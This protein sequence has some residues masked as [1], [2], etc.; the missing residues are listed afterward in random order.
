MNPYKILGVPETASEEDIKKAYRSLVKR[1]HPD[2]FAGDPKAQEASAEK[3]KQINQAYDM[4][5]KMRQGGQSYSGTQGYASGS[6][7]ARVRTALARGDLATAEMLLDGI[8][9]QSA[10]WHY[11]KGVILLRRGWYEGARQHLG[12][13][14]QMNPGNPEYKQ[15]WDVV[16][17]TGVS[18]QNFFGGANKPLMATLCASCAICSALSCCCR[19][20]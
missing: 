17:Q 15:A 11:L 2:R 6:A 3:L 19:Y 20:Y 12:M 13:A 8:S 5:I 18:Y 4:L 10:E 16:N 1:Y 14:Y 7:L 9:E